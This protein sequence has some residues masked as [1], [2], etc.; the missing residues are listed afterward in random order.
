MPIDLTD[1]ALVR[2]R[3]RPTPDLWEQTEPMTLIEA[4]ALLFPLGPV[5]LS[6][7][8]RARKRGQLATKSV[9]NRLYTTIEAMRAMTLPEMTPNPEPPAVT[10]PIPTLP[11]NHPQTSE[12]ADLLDMLQSRRAPKNRTRG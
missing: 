11:G 7:L 12:Q 5:S 4:V 3:A 8:R 9:C 2:V 10:A 1:P 6:T